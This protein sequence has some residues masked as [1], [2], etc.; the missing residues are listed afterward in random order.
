MI[1]NPELKILGFENSY[2]EANV[3]VFGA[4]FDGTVSYRPGSRFGPS[5]IRNESYG[6]ETYSPYQ[7]A[8][9]LMDIKGHDA[10]DLPLPFGDTKAV[11]DMIKSFTGEIVNDNKIPVMLGGEHLVTLPAVEAVLEKYLDLCIIHLDA[12][13][14]LREDYLGIKLSHAT[15]IRRIWE[16]VGDKRIWQF[17]IRSGEKYEFEW[18]RDHTFLTP[19]SLDGIEKALEVIGD[20]P[21]YLTIDLDVLDPS[22]FPGTGTPEHGGVTFK[23]LIAFLLKL[24]G[25]NIVGADLV[26]LAPHY[27]AS[28]IST[29]AACKLLREVALVIGAKI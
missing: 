16:K 1:Q 17:G 19:F 10:G 29:A 4:P 20:R 12:H 21:I 23:E 22:V 11:L 27:D 25:K 15:V 8:D 24:R 26:E 5:A 28:G 3:V 18:A 6:I 7:N 2:D 14:D 13:T 9:L